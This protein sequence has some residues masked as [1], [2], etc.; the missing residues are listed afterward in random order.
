[1]LRDI[2]DAPPVGG[3]DGDR[4]PEARRHHGRTRSAAYATLCGLT[5]TPSQYACGVD[6]VGPSDVKALI[7]SFPAYWGPRKQRWLNR[8]GDVIKDPTLNRDISPLYHL[9][10]IAR[11]S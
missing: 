10:A 5:F 7:E 2:S 9:D 8:F 4:R 3:E 1:M 6:I 11:R